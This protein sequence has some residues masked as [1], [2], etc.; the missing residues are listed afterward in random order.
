[1]TLKFFRNI[2]DAVYR[3][4]IQISEFKSAVRH[5]R[6]DIR[7]PKRRVAEIVVVIEKAAHRT[8][9]TISVGSQNI[10]IGN[11]CSRNED[12]GK[13]QTDKIFFQ[14]GKSLAFEKQCKTRHTIHKRR[15]KISFAVFDMNYRKR[16]QN[17]HNRR[18]DK[19]KSLMGRFVFFYADDKTGDE[20]DK[21]DIE[22]DIVYPPQDRTQ[23]HRYDNR[24]FRIP[25][26]THRKSLRHRSH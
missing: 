14:R 9:I 22:H 26:D 21:R 25:H 24:R 6:K 8:L 1:M 20:E 19:E 13:R 2:I 23:G 17:D 12:N 16:I 7:I 5:H 11:E 3:I 10:D 4:G 18:Y 15:D